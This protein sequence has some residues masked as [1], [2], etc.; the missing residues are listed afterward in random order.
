MALALQPPPGNEQIQDAVGSILADSVDIDFTY[1]DTTPSITAVITPTF[2]QEM[3]TL[4]A[5]MG[6]L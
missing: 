6:T 3:F 5:I 2:R 1:D 4:A